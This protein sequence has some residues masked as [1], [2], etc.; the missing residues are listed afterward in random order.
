MF[1][2]NKSQCIGVE[3]KDLSIRT[4]LRLVQETGDVLKDIESQTSTT[5]RARSWSVL[6]EN[7]ADLEM[8]AHPKDADIDEIL[9]YIPRCGQKRNP[10]DKQYVWRR[11]GLIYSP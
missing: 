11:S 10:T 5:P 1:C 3:N 6:K 8:R 4:W 9:A 7:L 2:S